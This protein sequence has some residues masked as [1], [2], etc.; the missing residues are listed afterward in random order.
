MS[1]GNQLLF[2]KGI[3]KR[4][5]ANTVLDNVNFAVEA[6]SV[7]VLMGEN[8]AGKSTL[9]KILSGIH[10][11]DA[12]EIILQEECVLLSNP[13][14]ATDLGIRVVH[15]EFSLVAGLSVAENI[16]LGNQPRTKWGWVNNSERTESAKKMLDLLGATIDPDTLVGELT[17]GERQLVEIA[18]ALV[19]D[20]KILILDEPTAALSAR[21]VD[22]LLSSVDR[23]KKLGVGLVYIS[24]RMEEVR[25]VGDRVSVLRDGKLVL[26]SDLSEVEDSALIQAMIGRPLDQQYPPRNFDLGDQLLEAQELSSPGA[27]EKITFSLRAGEVLGVVGPTGCGLNELGRAL[28]GLLPTSSGVVRLQG[29]E[30][31]LANARHAI[32][33]GLAYVPDDRKVAGLMPNSSVKFNASAAILRRLTKYGQPIAT[34]REN[35]AVESL[36]K[37]LN[38][39]APSNNTPIRLLSGGNQQKVVLGRWLLHGAR[40]FILAEPTRGVDVGAKEAIYTQ[41]NG[42]ASN[43][44]G[45]LLLTSDLMEAIGM[46]DRL[47]VMQCGRVIAE[48]ARGELSMPTVLAALYTQEAHAQPH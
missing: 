20:A 4:F 46:C 29:K 24:H 23:L 12:G 3:S 27:F 34:K 16:H 7:H 47:L 30:V 45:V 22:H 28:F 17:V 15:Q 41:I 37:Q 19:G 6:G 14:I 18:R 42:L 35:L 48:L 21:E 8:G 36:V 39:I 40:A 33:A 25:R 9:I 31:S 1:L 44:A 43:G 10:T 11:P 5:G 2:A 38:I 26:E 32:H 13:R